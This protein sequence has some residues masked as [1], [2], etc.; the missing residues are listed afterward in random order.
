MTVEEALAL[1]EAS[2]N[3]FW[4]EA[5]IKEMTNVRFQRPG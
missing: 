4:L 3:N 1:N 5:I 2:G